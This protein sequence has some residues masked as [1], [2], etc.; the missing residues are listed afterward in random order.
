[1]T[2]Y[3]Q[4]INNNILT[5]NPYFSSYIFYPN[6]K[7]SIH[8]NEV[9]PL[10]IY[11]FTNNKNLVIPDCGHPMHINCFCKFY[12]NKLISCS[13]CKKQIIEKREKR[14]VCR[15]RSVVPTPVMSSVDTRNGPR[16]VHTSYPAESEEISPDSLR[17]WYLHTD[18]ERKQMIEQLVEKFLSISPQ[19]FL[20]WQTYS[21]SYKN[22]LLSEL[23][24]FP[25]TS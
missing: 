16:P 21:I 11:D 3:D 9:C 17:C 19:L 7:I 20:A 1:M 22:S 14:V 6:I 5:N 4:L 13:I 8:K 25:H 12:E 18:Y 2:F 23:F 24:S 10:C 15:P